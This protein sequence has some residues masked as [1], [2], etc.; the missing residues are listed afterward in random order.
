MGFSRRDLLAGVSGALLTNAAEQPAFAEAEFYK[1]K[2]LTVLVNYAAGGP[3]DVEARLFARYIARHLDGAPNIIVQNMDGAGGLIGT[4]YLGEIAPRDGTVLGYLSGAAWQSASDSQPRRVD[5]RTYEFV[6][7]Q[8]GTS[9]YF[10]R[11]DVP[12]GMKDATDIAKA[13]G[14]IA[15]GLGVDDAKDILMRMTLDMLGVKFKYVNGYKG[16]QGARL[17]LQEGEI[18]FYSDGPAAYRA[19]IEPGLVNKGEAI[20]LFYDPGYNGVNFMVPKQMDG[21]DILPFHE[22]YGKIKGVEPSG[23]LWDAYRTIIALSGA[24]QRLIVMPPNVPQPAVDAV[25]KALAAMSEDKVY[26]DECLRIGF[27]PEYVVDSDVNDQVRNALTVSPEM[28][29]LIHA[30]TKNLPI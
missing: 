3:T 13:R 23:K 4:N 29:D 14:V 9:I 19:V 26:Q 1:N 11:T 15:G 28:K 10:I 12:P 18:N 6:V 25:R 27:L 21:L 2:R 30:Y 17:A 22:L 16:S 5:F 8:P 24:M 20:P 7:Y